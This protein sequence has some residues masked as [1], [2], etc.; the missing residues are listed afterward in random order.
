MQQVHTIFSFAA[1]DD[2]LKNDIRV[3]P[4]LDGL[5]AFGDTG[6]YCSR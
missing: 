1:D 6:W 4:D 2:F 3:K 5:G